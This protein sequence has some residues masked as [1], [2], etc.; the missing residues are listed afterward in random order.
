MG[1]LNY[2]NLPP[3]ANTSWGNPGDIA[4]PAKI[5][6]DGTITPGYFIP[7]PGST[8]P[9]PPSPCDTCAEAEKAAK[10]KKKT[11]LKK[12]V[13]YGPFYTTVST[14]MGGTGSSYGFGIQSTPSYGVSQSLCTTWGDSPGVTSTVSGSAYGVSYVDTQSL[15]APFSDAAHSSQICVPVSGSTPTF[16][17]GVSLGVGGIK[18]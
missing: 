6:P 13:S 11:T 15:N 17:P 9:P 18:F 4:V 1:G 5:N 3:G 7:P 8:P 10:D 14:P 12:K 16:S 2:S